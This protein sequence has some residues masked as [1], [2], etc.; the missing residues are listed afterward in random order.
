[1]KLRIKAFKLLFIST[2]MLITTHALAGAGDAD[3]EKTKSYSKSYNVS[4]S[5]AITIENKF[6]ETRLETWAN[7]EV[8]VDVQIRIKASNEERAL[9]L[10]NGISIE[11]GKSGSGVYFTT[12]IDQDNR[13]N[14]GRNN[15]TEMHIDYVVHLP[16]NNTLNLRTEF[17]DTYMPDYNGLV[18]ISNKFGSLK[19]GKLSSVKEI[20]IEFGKCEATAINNG[21]LTVKYSSFSVN[22]LSG[23]IDARIEFGDGTNITLDAGIKSFTLFNNYS[24]VKITTS[25]DISAK[26]DIETHFGDFKNRTDYSIRSDSDDENSRGPKFDYHYSG[27]TGGGSVPIKVKSNFGSVTLI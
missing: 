23:D 6:G 17:G 18:N 25:K 26:F 5:D 19:A 4:S 21:K 13:N 11:D 7:N 1:M 9:D 27:T 2:A 10:I 15:K 24:S 22:K 12:H 16:A 20:V 8:K 3:V 14:R